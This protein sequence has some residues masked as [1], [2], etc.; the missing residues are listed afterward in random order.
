MGSG[1]GTAGSR[2][3]TTTLRSN[4]QGLCGCTFPSQTGQG[5]DYESPGISGRRSGS[6]LIAGD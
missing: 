1:G 2:W 5:T 3:V 6:G 4:S